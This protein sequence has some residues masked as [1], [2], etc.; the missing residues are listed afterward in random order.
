MKNALVI[1][2]VQNYFINKA[3]KAIPKKISKFIKK[4]GNKF[5]FILFFQ[6]INDKKS[7]WVKLL[8]WEKML[9]GQEI[10]IA[11][12]LKKF[13][14]KDNLFIKKASFSIFRVKKFNIFIKKKNISKLYLCGLDTDACI[15]ASAL[16]AFERKFEVRVIEDLCSAHYGKKCHQNAIKSLKYNIL[17]KNFVIN[18]KDI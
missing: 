12:E 5:D 1:I 3:T 9:E 16:E 17:G 6:F 13:I 4:K 8:G 18:S 14:K 11:S 2:D 10:E 7:N 15:Y